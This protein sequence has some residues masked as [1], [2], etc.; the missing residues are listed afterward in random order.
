MTDVCKTE[1]ERV[2]DSR[3]IF[4]TGIGDRNIPA[5]A[6][7][8]RM[9]ENSKGGITLKNIPKTGRFK[10]DDP[11]MKENRGRASNFKFTL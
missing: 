5:K 2:R 1:R 6:K 4:D 10:K 7:R 3:F 9:G 8:Q 11:F